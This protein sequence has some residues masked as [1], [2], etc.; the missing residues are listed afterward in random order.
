[1]FYLPHNVSLNIYWL[2]ITVS[3]IFVYLLAL[4]PPT[5]ASKNKGKVNIVIEA[6]DNLQPGK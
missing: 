2:A 5:T 4:V 1:L 3:F 6:N